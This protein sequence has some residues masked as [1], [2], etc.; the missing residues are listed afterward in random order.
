MPAP[1]TR[2][3]FIQ[4]TAAAGLALGT[5]AVAAQEVSAPAVHGSDKAGK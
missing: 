2:R 5:G 1:T 4:T 3:R